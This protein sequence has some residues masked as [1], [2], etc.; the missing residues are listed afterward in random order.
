MNTR[1]VCVSACM[2]GLRKGFLVWSRCGFDK[3][4]NHSC[5]KQTPSPGWETENRLILHIKPHSPRLLIQACK[6]PICSWLSLSLFLFVTHVLPSLSYFT[7][8]LLFHTHWHAPIFPSERQTDIFS[9]LL[10]YFLSNRTAH[11]GIGCQRPNKSNP[12]DSNTLHWA[13]WLV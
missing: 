5:V 9:V 6:S 10:T 8:H 2:H 13:S 12:D 11:V 4:I 1:C 3:F 7:V